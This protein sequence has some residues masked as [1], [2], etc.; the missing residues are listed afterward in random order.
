MN[1]IVS[2]EY[3]WSSFNFYS[4]KLSI[5]DEAVTY[6]NLSF[7]FEKSYGMNNYIYELKGKLS[8]TDTRYYYGYIVDVSYL[9]K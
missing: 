4:E 9:G 1:V 8:H 5:F 6:K 3:D 7:S 2:E